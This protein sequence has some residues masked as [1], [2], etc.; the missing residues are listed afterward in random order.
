MKT[1]RIDQYICIDVDELIVEEMR[2]IIDQK[3]GRMLKE[4]KEYWA[5]LKEAAEV[6]LDTYGIETPANDGK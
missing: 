1:T 4:D 5:R 2:E 6:I 3:C